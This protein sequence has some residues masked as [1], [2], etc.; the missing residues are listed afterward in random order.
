MSHMQKIQKKREKVIQ[1]AL[2]Q[3]VMEVGHADWL[4]PKPHDLSLNQ[5][6]ESAFT[7]TRAVTKER[8]CICYNQVIQNTSGLSNIKV[9]FPLKYKFGPGGRKGG[10]SSGKSSKSQVSVVTIGLTAALPAGKKRE[11]M[12]SPFKGMPRSFT[13]HFCSHPFGPEFCQMRTHN[14]KDGQEMSFLL[15]MAMCP[16]KILLVWKTEKVDTGKKSKI[17]PTCGIM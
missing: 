17:S 8:T 6:Q 7:K 2:K 13:Y 14:C 1:L 9:Y 16:A 4:T 10:L 3:S 5:A 11:S 15:R 12:S